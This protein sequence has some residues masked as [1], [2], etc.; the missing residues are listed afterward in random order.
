M[1]LTAFVIACLLTAC[2]GG[3][4]GFDTTAS[5]IRTYSP[6]GA[7]PQATTMTGSVTTSD[8]NP[9]L[10]I[11]CVTPSTTVAAAK[12]A[13]NAYSLALPAQDKYESDKILA[14]HALWEI[15]LFNDKNNNGIYDYNTAP[16]KANERD[17]VIPTLESYRLAYKGYTSTPQSFIFMPH[18]DFQRGWI[19]VFRP[20]A[21]PLQ[22]HQ[23]FTRKFPLTAS[24]YFENRRFK[25]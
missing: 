5:E 10:T 7:A 16:T 18:N 20:G 14:V 2:T 24:N 9:N 23:D 6:A 13:N 17:I 11:A 3:R 22:Y 15:V 8:D 4:P 12:I 1:R 21:Q 25:Q 19:V